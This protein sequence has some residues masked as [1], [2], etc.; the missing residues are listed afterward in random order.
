MVELVGTR[1]IVA[2]ATRVITVVDTKGI[3]ADVVAA[4]AVVGEVVEAAGKVNGVV[5]HLH[6]IDEWLSRQATCPVCR[7]DV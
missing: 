1:V 6:C 3:V 4:A 5:F 7:K 2:V